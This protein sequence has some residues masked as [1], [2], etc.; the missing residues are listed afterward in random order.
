MSREQR[1]TGDGCP[2][3][4]AVDEDDALPVPPSAVPSASPSV[5]IAEGTDTIGSAIRLSMASEDPVEG[6][7]SPPLSIRE[8]TLTDLSHIVLFNIRLAWES[9][10][11]HLS[12]ERVTLGV[13]GILEDST[14]GRYILALVHG[15][16]VGQLMIFPEWN[17]WRGGWIWWIDNVYVA[18]P[19]RR[20]GVCRALFR[21]VQQ[22]AAAC[23][24]VGIRLHV[25]PENFP[26]QQAYRKLGLSTGGLMME[27]FLGHDG[28][29][30]PV[31]ANLSEAK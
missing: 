26:A 22:L 9:V 2:P 14:R 12:E 13:R 23:G 3:A 5:C 27:W 25:A 18:R 4:T 20:F 17:D 19:L 24:A 7:G 29:S 15:E 30:S 1:Q 6:D 8:A 16:R 28:G 10:R 11:K 31:L 21:H